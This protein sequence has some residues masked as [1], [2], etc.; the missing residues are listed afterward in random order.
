MLLNND[1]FAET[2]RI[3]QDAEGNGAVI[4]IH[5]L[6]MAE[7]LMEP[8]FGDTVDIIRATAVDPAVDTEVKKPYIVIRDKVY[9]Q[10]A[11]A[12]RT[13]NTIF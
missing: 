11:D 5:P 13:G 4:N 9:F 3:I 10:T 12:P 8:S 7:L 2:R 6:D 1:F